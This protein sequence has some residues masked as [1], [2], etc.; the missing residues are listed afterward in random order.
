M[1]K[2]GIL[3]AV[4]LFGFGSLAWGQEEAETT[5]EGEGAVASETVPADDEEGAVASDTADEASDTEAEEDT[6]TEVVEEIEA[7]SVTAAEAAPVTAVTSESKDQDN[8]PAQ[9]KLA[10]GD[11]GKVWGVSVILDHALGTGVFAAE[12]TLSSTNAYVAQSWGIRPVYKFKLLDHNLRLSGKIG[13]D[14]E[15]TTPNSNPAR[16]FD[17]KDIGVSLSDP[18]LWTEPFTEI[19]FSASV[20]LTFATSYKSINSAERWLGA[21]AAVG[22]GRAIGPV[23]LKYGFGFTKNFNGSRLAQSVS[24]VGLRQTDLAGLPSVRGPGTFTDPGDFGI[25]FN[26]SFSIS[27]SFSAT[28]NILDELSVTYAVSLVNGFKYCADNVCVDD[29]FTSVNA[30]TG[31]GRTDM[32]WP[33]L[34]VTYVLDGV[35]EKVYPL[36][37]T[38]MVSAGLTALHPAQTENNDGIM[39]PF[40]Y[41]VLGNRSTE[42]LA[43][44]YLSL[45]G[46]Y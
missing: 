7:T 34:D 38:L 35:M 33:T 24:D 26:T 30:D 44:Y 41:N 23:Y 43:S 8:R 28:Y 31:R 37:F 45:A 27:N 15:L 46:V 3:T 42:N 12:D 40:F 10:E 17:F 20:G 14:I 6:A 21:K 29:E 13:F 2:L 19:M 18:V 36:P 9:L 39:W 32:L 4:A 5:S 1:N 11:T 25:G 22:A 16:R